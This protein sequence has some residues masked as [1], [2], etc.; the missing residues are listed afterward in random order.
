[1][2]SQHVT[3]VLCAAEPHGSSAAI[4]QLLA[5]GKEH[6]VQAIALVGD[7]GA[8]T[9]DPSEY[10]SLF[11]A[12]AGAQLP[13]YWV[14]GVDD[15]P[16]A[17]YLREAQ[18]VEVVFPF[19]HGVHGTMAF[20]PGGH[21]IFAGFGGDVSDDPEAPRDETEHLSY[22]RW[23]PEYH[24]KLV[25]E[26]DEHQLVLLFWSPPAH[27]RHADRGSEALAEL[28]GTHRPRLV[29]CGGERNSD[30]LGRSMVVAPGSLVD[31]QYAVADLYDRQIHMHEFAA[32]G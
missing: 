25:R 11:R 5:A 30:M 12:L 18:N 28:V 8:G 15:A 2:A 13:S 24:L 23:E 6:Q 19:L 32:A 3:R 31:G 17:E 21:V 10:R 16:V 9:G 1:M 7:L 20:A 14:P 26:L 27:K 4:E 22:P 29:V